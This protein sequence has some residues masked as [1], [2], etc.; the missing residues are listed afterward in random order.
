METRQRIKKTILLCREENGGN[1][2]SKFTAGKIIAENRSSICYRASD[3]D[4]REGVL[5]EYYPQ[6]GSIELERRNGQLVC[7]EDS[8]ENR[9][10][11]NELKGKY[12][13]SYY[14][15]SDYMK[16]N[17]NCELG[18]FIPPYYIYN[19]CNR[20]SQP[21]GSVYIW[22]PCREAE[23]LANYFNYIRKMPIKDSMKK[24]AA[25]LKAIISLTKCVGTLHSS[26]MLHCGISP[27]SFGFEK[28]GS[29]TV[30]KAIQMLDLSTICNAEKAVTGMVGE[31]GFCDP[32]LKEK[33]SSVK[34]DIFSIGTMLFYALVDTE[35]TKENGYI[36][37]PEYL[38][39]LALMVRDSKMMKAADYPRL[40]GMLSDIMTSCLCG[41]KNRYKDCGELL[42]ALENAYSC[43]I[44]LKNEG[45]NS[46]EDSNPVTMIQYQL[47]ENPLYKYMT[48]DETEIN[49]LIVGFANY[50]QKFLDC[51]LQLG[52]MQGKKLNVSVISPEPKDK[53]NYFNERPALKY[54]CYINGVL[55]E[56][57]KDGDKELKLGESG[58]ISYGNI[59]FLSNI[60]ELES[61]KERVE[62]VKKPAFA[63]KIISENFI[64][65]NGNNKLRYVF[66]DIGNNDTNK[67]AAGQFAKFL[68][69]KAVISYADRKIVPDAKSSS[70]ICPVYVNAEVKNHKCYPEIMRMAFNTHLLWEKDLNCDYKRIK[71]NFEDPYNC[72]ASI[73]SVISVKYKLHSI[74]IDL[75]EGFETAAAEYE[76]I[77]AKK[78]Y[79]SIRDNLICDEHNRWVA[80]KLCQ[81]WQQFDDISKCAYGMT[82]DEINKRHIC[83]CP[84]D[85]KQKLKGLTKK[86]WIDKKDFEKLDALDK[87]SVEL[88]IAYLK[89]ANKVREQ[90]LLHDGFVER[91]ESL[92]VDNIQARYIFNEWVACINEI[93]NNN[94]DSIKNYNN[95]KNAF[96]NAIAGIYKEESIIKEVEAFDN[97]FKPVRLSLEYRDWKDSDAAIVDNIPFLLT[98]SQKMC[99]VIPFSAEKDK[100]FLNVAAATAASPSN[101]IYLYNI[102]EAENINELTE[103]IP[104]VTSYMNKKN[105][106]ADV[107]FFVFYPSKLA[108]NN[109]AK[110]DNSAAKADNNTKKLDK[111]S[112][113]KNKAAKFNNNNAKEPDN[114]AA[115]ADSNEFTEKIK[116]LSEIT[117]VTA[118]AYETEENI[119][120]L[121]IERLSN[122]CRNFDLTAAEIND[123]GLCK[124]RLDGNFYSKRDSKN[125][126]VIPLYRYDYKKSCFTETIGCEQLNYISQTPQL[127]VTEMTSLAGAVRCSSGQSNFD[128]ESVK[129][130]W[131]M[132]L[133]N[134]TAW[135]GLCCILGKHAEENDCLYNVNCPKEAKD[136]CF[137]LPDYCVK[138]ARKILEYLKRKNWIYEDRLELISAGRCKVSFKSAY[139]TEVDD[140]DNIINDINFEKL[141]TNI[142]ALAMP[143][144]I[145]TDDFEVKGKSIVKIYYDDLNVKD[146][147]LFE[148]GTDGGNVGKY[149]D[150]LK[151]FKNEGYILN[152]KESGN[153]VS[154]TYASRDVKELLIMEGKILELYVYNAAK[155]SGEFDNVV[156][157]IEVDWNNTGLKNEFD[158][159]ITKGFR[160]VLI[161]C[162]ARR[163]FSRD[164]VYKVG[165]LASQLGKNVVPVLI[166][167]TQEAPNVGDNVKL[168]RMEDV[169]KN[170]QSIADILSDILEGR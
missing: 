24:I 108:E 26:G 29:E 39:R 87:V 2:Q 45:N 143:D 126:P 109:T 138:G 133:K 20:Q 72:N 121:L 54:F 12:V 141:F 51:V 59:T 110:A 168:I 66:I 17:K 88:E 93:W 27:Y 140:K 8:D 132:Y 163:N 52:Q 34:T 75:D 118:I 96:L 155:N 62:Y 113:K 4:G 115:K 91:V 22:R 79:Q 25:V 120:Q 122:K 3:E 42:V 150:L 82:K 7:A 23:S 170:E 128:E 129:F 44:E 65:K 47:Y 63:E 81:G 161:E 55:T 92:L 107:E 14:E 154:F 102:K 90:D 117:Q 61:V 158:C 134:R 57:S 68:K 28:R 83:I 98:Y 159:M 106:R 164:H 149:K 100:L 131:N 97:V 9:N 162:K 48:D 165:Y 111:K 146:V 13:K 144:Y 50:G 31:E 6:D 114:N 95:L 16:K 112:K 1:K 166:I 19:G 148:S 32:N 85:P 30:V 152:Y 99:M 33:K 35:E 56:K 151:A 89:A 53:Y 84:S 5:L 40:R 130:F 125:N 67:K 94:A 167:D 156:T 123:A 37:K 64:D 127:T 116:K 124:L 145:S 21:C 103:T 142:N 58:R 78:E 15:L 71:K 153:T 147:N 77:K 43:L 38:S 139:Y 18:D 160:A 74:G 73:A 41:V 69:K 10:K 76:D 46:H 136:Y 135:K 80:D 36:Y 60:S 104:Y 169:L 49:V 137:Y 119:P 105:F 70:D 11:F 157:S 101:I 86:D